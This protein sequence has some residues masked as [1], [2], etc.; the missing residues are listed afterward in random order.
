MYKV[1]QTDFNLDQSFDTIADA[2]DLA[3]TFPIKKRPLVIGPVYRKWL[4]RKDHGLDDKDYLANIPADL[5][6]KYS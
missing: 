2:M 5:A 1:I 3:D 6:P 4:D